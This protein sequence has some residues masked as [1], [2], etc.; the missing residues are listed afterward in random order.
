MQHYQTQANLNALEFGYRQIIRPLKDGLV[1][2]LL[3]L[4]TPK[5]VE[6]AG[7]GFWWWWTGGGAA[8]AAALVVDQKKLGT[9]LQT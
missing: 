3:A 8:G 4:A 9:C 5:G 6:P 7:V 2:L 1:V